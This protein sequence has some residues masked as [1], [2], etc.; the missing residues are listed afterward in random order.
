MRT[1][2]C[3]VLLCLHVA[4]NASSESTEM[5]RA[6]DTMQEVYHVS[7][8]YDSALADVTPA[9]RPLPDKTLAENL[10]IV[11]GGTGIKWEIKDEYVLLFRQNKY[12]FSGYVCQNNGESLINVTVYDKTTRTGTLTDEHG[13]FSITLPEGKHVL[14][15][16]YI[17]YEEV[18]KELDLQSDYF[19]TI[20]LKE[21]TTALAGVEVTANLNDPLFTT[22]TGKVSFTPELLN[23]EFSLLSS[24]D[25][26]KSI[27]NLPGV[28]SG[29]ELLSGL[30]VHGGRND[31][32]MFCWT[33]LRCIRSI[34]WADCFRHSIRTW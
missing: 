16:S 11:F 27:Q 32:N 24:P 9:G 30:Y 20:Y 4:A 29:T 25:L 31:E 21:S 23:T 34:I 22:Q 7:F 14:R 1:F 8:V 17:G 3:A 10:N 15:V 26:V 33:V 28:S 5:K 6:I 18:V 19:G 13:F 12:T 2:F